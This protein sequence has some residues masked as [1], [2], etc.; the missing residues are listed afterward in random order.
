MKSPLT[1]IDDLVRF[2]G[3]VK[4]V[5]DSKHTHVVYI[6]I[7]FTDFIVFS[8][9]SILLVVPS[10]NDLCILGAEHDGRNDGLKVV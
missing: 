1:S 2:G 4:D 3:Q 10:V 7:S 9:D 6:D 5:F 8:M